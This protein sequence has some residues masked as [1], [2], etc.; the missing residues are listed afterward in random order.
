[1]NFGLVYVVIE[2]TWLE[3]GKSWDGGV[4]NAFTAL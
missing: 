4:F 2:E 1:M 3:E